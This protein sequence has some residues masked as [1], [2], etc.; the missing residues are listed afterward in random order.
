MMRMA[1]PVAKP[2]I[3]GWLSRLATT[4]RRNTPNSSRKAPASAA[5]CSASAVYSAL[6][7]AASGA[8]AEA[9][10]NETTATGPTASVRDEPNAA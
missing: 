1:E 5:S 8:S 3:T 10:I 6:P 7:A 2:A 4:P 9:V